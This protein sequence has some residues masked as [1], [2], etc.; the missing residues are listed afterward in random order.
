MKEEDIN[1]S[2]LMTFHDTHDHELADEEK[3]SGVQLGGEEDNAEDRL[4]RSRDR[5]RE[6]ARRTRLR[7]K[8][9]LQ[10]LQSRVKELQ[11]ESRMLRQTVEECSIASILL[12]LS[13]GD[14]KAQDDE[15]TEIQ[16]ACNAET[17]RTFFTM[18]GKRKRFISDAGD[19]PPPMKLKIKGQTTL[20]GG[21]G[22]KSHIN[23]KTGVYLDETGEQKQLTSDELE[24]LRRERNRMHA[25]MTRDRKKLFISS[26]EKTIA[27]LEQNNK[28]MRDILAKQAVQ[29]SGVIVP[30][31]SVTPE[32]SPLLTSSDVSTTSVPPLCSSAIPITNAEIHKEE[33]PA[34]G[35]SHVEIG[36]SVVA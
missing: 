17:E 23:W 36:Y 21:A 16:N 8:A 26:V 2:S 20:V 6:H 34:S 28:R 29:H 12:G 33:V 11:D 18:T 27:E 1:D 5:N 10:G 22:G 32:P 15:F 7:K 4:A 3:A 19:G 30:T 24:S 31:K 9:Q 25:K 14:T 13:S 35:N